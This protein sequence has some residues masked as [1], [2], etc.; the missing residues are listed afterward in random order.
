MSNTG[1]TGGGII[2]S[3]SQTVSSAANVGLKS[4]N[5]CD[6]ADRI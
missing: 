1:N 6:K 4:L 5:T 3:I 2:D